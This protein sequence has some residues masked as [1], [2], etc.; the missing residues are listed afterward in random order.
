MLA[1]H[2]SHWKHFCKRHIEIVGNNGFIYGNKVKRVHIWATSTFV[3]DEPFRRQHLQKCVYRMICTSGP[4]VFLFFTKAQSSEEKKKVQHEHAGHTCST[5]C[6][7]TMLL[8]TLILVSV[9]YDRLDAWAFPDTSGHVWLTLRKPTSAS[10]K[11]SKIATSGAERHKCR[12]QFSHSRFRASKNGWGDR[13]EVF[14]FPRQTRFATFVACFDCAHNAFYFLLLD[15]LTL[16]KT[17][18]GFCSRIV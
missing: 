8:E 10:S 4:Q 7:H 9:L 17:M 3:I 2:S 6:K 18:A 12:D 1:L 13:S 14:L 16:P 15:L 11:A 5:S